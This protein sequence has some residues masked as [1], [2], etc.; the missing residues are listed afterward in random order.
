MIDWCQL[1]QRNRRETYWWKWAVAMTFVVP[2]AAAAPKVSVVVGSLLPEEGGPRRT[3][4]SPLTSPFGVD[5]NRQGDMYIVELE[6]GRV[7]ERSSDGTFRTISGNGQ[8]GYGGDGGP[9]Q[10]A[11]F[12]GMHNVAVTP[13]G[14]VFISDSWNHCIRRI[15]KSSGL[16]ST[17]AG[18]GEPGFAGDGG[19]AAS[20]RFNYLMCVTLNQAGDKLFIADL[21][22]RRIRLI[23]LP[24]EVVTTVAGN[25]EQGVPHDGD[26]AARSPLVDPRAVAVDSTD[27]IYVLERSGHA[28][29]VIQPNGRIFT[30]AG[31][32]KP[33]AL[34]GKALEAQLNSPKHLCVDDADNVFIADDQNQAIRKYD[35]RAETL[36]TV[37]GRG[38]GQPA[39][40]LSRPHGVCFEQGKL[41]VVD[42]GHDRV[43]RVDEL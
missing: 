24:T 2:T 32:G 27:R 5:F 38:I 34:D 13:E 21:R 36:T 17:I 7:H 43:L 16:I 33:G 10:A 35:P 29:R 40:Q 18:T 37:L 26:S 12:N 1:K 6:G 11:V 14:D 25:G 42:T 30:V 23:D 4:T 31:T 19:P 8:A 28:L 9:A 22:N 39:I 15:D 41:Y 3:A 20:A